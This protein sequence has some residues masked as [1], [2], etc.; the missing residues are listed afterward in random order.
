[1]SPSL[2]SGAAGT[3]MGPLT[4]YFVATIQLTG[5]LYT[6]SR[7][8]NSHDSLIA[9]HHRSDYISSLFAQERA[10]TEQRID[11]Q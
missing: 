4:C 6:C 3:R 1:V 11:T 2:V 9:F 5:H 8:Q 7:R 10:R